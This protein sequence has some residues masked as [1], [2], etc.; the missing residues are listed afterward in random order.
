[1]IYDTSLGHDSQL[2]LCIRNS[3]MRGEED[4]RK[5]TSGIVVYARRTIVIWKSKKERVV[6]QS[7]MQAE[8]IATTYGK[9]QIDWLRDLV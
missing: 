4:T 1:M 5:S 3:D 8:M 9:V 6:A 7:T 2:I